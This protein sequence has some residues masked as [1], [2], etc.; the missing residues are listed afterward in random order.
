MTEDNGNQVL[1]TFI[2]MK[3]DAGCNEIAPA[4]SFDQF[5][6]NVS[7][8]MNMMPHSEQKGF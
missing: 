3:M 6:E 7:M 1:D 5:H 2:F 8:L 4:I